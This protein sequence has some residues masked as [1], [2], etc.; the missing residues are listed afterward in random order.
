MWKIIIFRNEYN[1]P[2][3]IVKE[4][5]QKANINISFF[6][7]DSKN[8][9]NKL[10][11][12][13]SN[14]ISNLSIVDLC[15][16]CQFVLNFTYALVANEIGADCVCPDSGMFSVNF[17]RN[18]M[19][20]FHYF[21]VFETKKYKVIDRSKE[22][23]HINIYKFDSFGMKCQLSFFHNYKFDESESKISSDLLN[24]LCDELI[25]EKLEIIKY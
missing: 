22:N 10:M 9:Q 13:I 4:V 8:I 14:E 5:E 23:A 18:I 3:D 6:V 12:C 19:V 1:I 15:T 21:N 7:A 25:S 17:M 24:R 2:L 20:P 16:V 11:K